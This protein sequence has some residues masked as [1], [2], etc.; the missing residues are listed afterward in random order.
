MTDRVIDAEMLRG[1]AFVGL[2]MAIVTLA[3]LDLSL[4]GGLI[5]GT[6]ELD[7]ARS[8][9][10]TTL[11][12]AQLYNCFNARSDR[13]SAFN[14]IFT[15]RLLWLAIGASVVM[16][17]AVLHLAFLNEPFSTTPLAL[18][19][20]AICAALA[21]AVLWATE[22]RKLLLRRHAANR[23]MLAKCPERPDRA[24]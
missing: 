7:H 13:T 11:V 18:A 2:V 14:G 17:V 10:F 1:M 9:A 22:L 3:A 6:G 24:E 19:D 15:N 23:P 16:Q 21:S 12:L 20:W 4:P 8:M 5:E